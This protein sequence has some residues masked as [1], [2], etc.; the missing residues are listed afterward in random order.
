MNIGIVVWDQEGYRMGVDRAALDRVTRQ[1][2]WLAP[3]G[4]LALEPL[5]SQTLDQVRPFDPDAFRALL[6]RQ[7]RDSLVVTDPRYTTLS[8]NSLN[9]LDVTLDRLLARVVRPRKNSG[10]GGASPEAELRKRFREWLDNKAMEPGR[11]FQGSSGRNRKIAFYAN[12]TANLAVDTLRLG[13][14]KADDILSRADAEAFKIVDIR[15]GIKSDQLQFVVYCAI[16]ADPQL[17]EVNAN[18]QRTI[19]SAGA[20]VRT[21][22][23]EVKALVDEVIR[24]PLL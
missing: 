13:V 24:L 21:D 5:L 19:E 16:K 1:S 11:V 23:D 20:L 17:A 9:A 18:A 14:S 7:N 2:P 8:D 3:D 4:L 12:S 10:G 15:R 22:P 6:E